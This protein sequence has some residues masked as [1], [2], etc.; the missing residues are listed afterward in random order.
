MQESFRSFSTG[1]FV[2]FREGQAVLDRESFG[3]E[4][5]ELGNDGLAVKSKKILVAT[6]IEPRPKPVLEIDR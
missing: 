6:R 1:C 5:V 2:D 3:V 4:E